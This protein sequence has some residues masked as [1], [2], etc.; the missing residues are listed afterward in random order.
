[1]V[2][3]NPP[4]PATPFAE[5]AEKAYRS[6]DTVRDRCGSVVSAEEP[7]A[8]PESVRPRPRFRSEAH[9]VLVGEGTLRRQLEEQAQNLGLA[10]QD[11]LPGTA[12]RYF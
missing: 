8:A 10:G 12:N 1:M 3:L 7:R 5:F 6:L 2:F 9:L 4:W 11:P